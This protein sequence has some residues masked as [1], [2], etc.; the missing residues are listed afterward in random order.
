MMKKESK[1]DNKK[2]LPMLSKAM[3]RTYVDEVY[4]SRVLRSKLDIN[5]GCPFSQ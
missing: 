2:G 1:E 3:V 4:R 5:N